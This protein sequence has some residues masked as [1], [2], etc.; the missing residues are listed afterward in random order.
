MTAFISA[1]SAIFWGLLVL[2]ILVFIHEGGHFLAARAFGIRVKEFYLGLPCKLRLHHASKKTGT[3]YGVTPLL[4]GGYT[5]VCG[6]E[7][8]ATGHLASVL[9][10]VQAEGKTNHVKIAEALGVDEE[11][12]LS[13]LSTLVDWGSIEAAAEDDVKTDADTELVWVQTAK[14]DSALLTKYDRAHNF[15]EA[16]TTEAGIPRVPNM[17]AAAFLKEEKKHT[18]LSRGFFGR[19]LILVAGACI[20]ILFGFFLMVFVL[21]VVGTPA[22]SDSNQIASV[23]PGS[24]A[25]TAGISAGDTILSINGVQTESWTEIVQALSEPLQNESALHITYTHDDVEHTADVTPTSAGEKFGISASVE[26]VHLGFFEAC[27]QAWSYIAAT[28]AYIIQLF[29]PDKIGDVI[30]NSTSVIGISVMASNAVSSGIGSILMLVAA[31]SLS[32]GFMNLLPLPPLDGGK[33]V[34]ELIQAIIR[35]PLPAK[36]VQIISYVG[37]FIFILLFIVLLRQDIIRFVLGG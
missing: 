2:S 7:E 26:N 24:L 28:F 21:S 30:S 32:L 34:I 27:A 15:H 14:R 18:Y 16:G 33:V 31:V 10:Y 36:V 1:I 37:I 3:D 8:A 12:A 35:R 17:D 22:V 9:E 13:A 11:V 19:F 20:N 25:E 4:L 23:A 5:L 29:Q 6:M